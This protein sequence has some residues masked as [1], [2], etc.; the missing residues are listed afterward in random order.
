MNVPKSSLDQEMIASLLKKDDEKQQE[1]VNARIKKG[2][3]PTEPR[4]YETW[5]RLPTH[6]RE[7]TN[8]DCIDPRDNTLGKS[9]V[10]EVNGSEICRYC[11]LA[12][13]NPTVT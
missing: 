3:Y 4:T 11:F 6:F 12:G 10:A 2:K 13:A 7:C 1:K 5:F 9:M 8:K